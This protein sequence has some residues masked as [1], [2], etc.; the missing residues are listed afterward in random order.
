M[1][2]KQR[3]IRQIPETTHVGFAARL[4]LEQFRIES[5]DSKVQK[6]INSSIKLVISL[7]KKV[8]SPLK[9]TI[10]K[11]AV[12]ANPLHI[13]SKT[14]KVVLNNYFSLIL[15]KFFRA[16]RIT[17]KTTEL[18]KEQQKAIFDVVDESEIAFNCFNDFDYRGDNIPAFF[19][20]KMGASNQF[21]KYG[22]FLKFFL[23]WCIASQQ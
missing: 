12:C 2:T 11:S 15:Q 1:T 8:K 10:V 23:H 9:Q 17:S 19:A 16:S 6:S 21:V 4:K 5:S 18:A 22:M 20:D 14:K 3:Y 13:L 7:L